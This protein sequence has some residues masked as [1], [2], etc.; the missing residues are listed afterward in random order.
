MI[1][2]SVTR[3]PNLLLCRGLLKNLLERVLGNDVTVVTNSAK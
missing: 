2:T 3:F 1:V